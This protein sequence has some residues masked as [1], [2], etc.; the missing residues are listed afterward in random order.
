[1]IL[2]TEARVSDIIE[3]WSK[4]YTSTDPDYDIKVVRH[5]V[6]QTTGKVLFVL[7]KTEKVKA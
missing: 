7:E 4:D 6:D 3:H 5:S 1:M 2:Y